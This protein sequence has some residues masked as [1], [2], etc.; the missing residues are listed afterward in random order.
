MFKPYEPKTYGQN[1]FKINI[2]PSLWTLQEILLDK[3]LD[4]VDKKYFEMTPTTK[5]SQSDDENNTLTNEKEG[6]I[7]EIHKKSIRFK[8]KASSLFILRNITHI[9]NYEKAMNESKY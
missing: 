8:G 9:I 6:A 7:F 2:Q 4:S 1:S 3:T 5:D